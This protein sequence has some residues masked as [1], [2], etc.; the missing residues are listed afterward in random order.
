MTWTP[1]A[2]RLS[3]PR[4]LHPVAWWGWGLLLAGAA[5]R[6]LNPLHLLAIIGVAVVVVLLRQEVGTRGSLSIFLAL[7]GLAVV[8]R[9]VMTVL[10]GSGVEGLTVL[11][12]LPQVPLPDWMAGV[13]LGGPVTLEAMLDSLYHGLQIAAVLVCLGACNVLADPRRL[14][15]YLPATLYDVG[16]AVVV[17]LT[18]VPQLADD[19]RAVRRAWRLRGHDGR[20]VRELARLVVPVLERS[21]E[22]SMD[23][24]ASMESRGYGRAPR[25][26]GLRRR[27][28]ALT[29]VGLVGVLI[30]LYGLLDSSAPA[31]LGVPALLAGCGCAAASLLTGVRAHRRRPYRPD[32][33]RAPEWLVLLSGVVPV[34]AMAVAAG[35]R[36][37][38]LTPVQVPASAPDLWAPLLLALLVPLAAGVLAPRTPRRVELEERLA[39]RR[40]AVAA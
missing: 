12:D 4:L 5:S 9:L 24:A 34:A 23:L 40:T 31:L 21:F 28:S 36:P 19:A 1:P 2:D 11:V 35:R 37:E 3:R 13:R 14:L 10:L 15:R 26:A 20:G 39:A 6:T 29:L 22:R 8:V 27:A 7:A 38:T 18:Y 33:W 25:D 17:A 16:T 30:G 32:P